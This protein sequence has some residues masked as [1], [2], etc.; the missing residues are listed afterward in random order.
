MMF[1]K[2]GLALLYIGL[3][4]VIYIY[5]ESILVWMREADNVFMVAMIATLMALFPVIPYPVVGGVIGAAYGP[6]LGGLVTW[7]GSASASILMFLFVRYGY[8]E[9]GVR[10]LHKRKG[11]DKITTLFE[12]N[13]F[14]MIL[15][16]RMIPVIPSIIVNI[17]SAISR[18]SFAAYAVASSIGKIPAM[19]LFALVGNNVVSNPK[20]IIITIGV[21]S[22]FLALSLYIYRIWKGSYKA[23][24]GV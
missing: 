21:Y 10:M 24:K 7:T 2:M 5:G 3:A 17:Y 9:W 15:F 4:I 6:A 13:A 16:A 1:K 8:Q 12:K 14:L 19:L 20:N 23:Y 11:I 22:V 18:V